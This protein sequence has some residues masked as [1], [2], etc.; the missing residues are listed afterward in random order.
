MTFT[1]NLAGSN[2]VGFRCLDWPGEPHV[3]ASNSGTSTPIHPTVFFLRCDYLILNS[4]VLVIL[5][6]GEWRDRESLN[7]WCDLFD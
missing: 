6:K 5:V 7:G 1:G 2:D 3:L 4:M